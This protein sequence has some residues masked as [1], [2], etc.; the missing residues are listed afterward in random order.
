MLC[1]GLTGAKFVGR[2]QAARGDATS[3][4]PVTTTTSVGA[5][6]Q[7]ARR[8]TCA[9]VGGLREV[10]TGREA[11]AD[12]QVQTIATANAEPGIGFTFTSALCRAF[13]RTSSV[14]V[15]IAAVGALVSHAAT[16]LAGRLW[17]LLGVATVPA[18][19]SPPLAV[20]P[21][22]NLQRREVPD[23]GDLLTLSLSS[24]RPER[25]SERQSSKSGRAGIAMSQGAATETAVVTA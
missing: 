11:Q 22:L 21:C 17:R 23:G 13:H 25:G 3:L 16:K 9:K 7:R 1:R 18:P 24:D 6:A 20:S 12:R 19:R 15:G 10:R 8:P 4:R 14:R 2:P 5:G